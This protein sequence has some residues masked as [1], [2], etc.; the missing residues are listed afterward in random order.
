MNQ[1]DQLR[2]RVIVLKCQ[3][4]DRAAWDE[5][6]RHYNPPLAYYLRRLTGRDQTG[7]DVQQE[8]WLAVVRNIARLKSPEAFTVWLYRI[9]RSKA[10]SRLPAYRKD[11]PLEEEPAAPVE[12]P[13]DETF[14]ESDMARVHAALDGLR[15]E[16]RDVL[17]LRFMEDLSYEEIAA[18]VDCGVGTVR[19][20]IHYGK[21]ALRR[22]LEKDHE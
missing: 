14:S 12:I 11:A 18:V 5:L 7:D 22:Q 6:Y 10:M 8:V 13:D 2:H 21:R 15:P 20:R 9:A 16:H 4:G 1:L 3:L 17:L 19:S